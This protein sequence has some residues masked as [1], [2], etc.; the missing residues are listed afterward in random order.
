[1]KLV[2]KLLGAALMASAATV[3][4][5]GVASAEGELSANVALTSNYVWRGVTQ[6]TGDFAI[7]GGIDYAT[8]FF[9]VGTWASSVD[10]FGIDAS[11]ELDFYAGI[12][13]SLGPVSFD[14]GVIFYNYPSTT[15]DSDFIELAASASYSPIEPLS[16]GLGFYASNDYLATGDE[17]LFIEATVG[18]TIT[19][20]FSVSGGYG[21]F[22]QGPTL[23]EYDTWNIGATYSV[24]GL[25]FDLRYF[26]TD[27]LGLGEEIAFTISRSF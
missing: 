18:Y 10:D 20:A 16:L 13:P 21:N 8:D 25:G 7:Q 17:S 9:Y 4:T 14:L 23:G 5:T 2:Q 15:A 3:A 22:D 6:S 26:D 24:F 12:T 1:M 11:T 27:G 19:E